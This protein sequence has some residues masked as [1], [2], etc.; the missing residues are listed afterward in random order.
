[1]AVLKH[2]VDACQ[3]EQTSIR[4]EQADLEMKVDGELLMISIYFVDL[5]HLRR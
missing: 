2:G 1:M 3:L 5:C 4:T